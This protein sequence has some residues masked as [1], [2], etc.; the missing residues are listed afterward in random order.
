M[1]KNLVIVESP[2]KAK[3]IERYIGKNY[4]VKASM[5][6][7][8]DIPKS[9]MG[10]DVENEYALKYITIRGKG[11]TLKELRKEAKKAT[12]IYLAADPDREGEAIAWH[13]AYALNVDKQSN[14]RVVFNEIT[15]D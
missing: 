12:N 2:A 10:V 4:K 3:T 15:K 9:K 13:L 8:R 14:C 6:H 11:E 5:G 7:V 1:T